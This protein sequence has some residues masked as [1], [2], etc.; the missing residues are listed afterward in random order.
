MKEKRNDWLIKVTY[1]SE[2]LQYVVRYI[3]ILNATKREVIRNTQ[4]L[5]ENSVIH[6]Y[7]LE[8]FL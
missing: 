3:N 4:S 5:P 8:A 1:V 6:I 2:N 7:K